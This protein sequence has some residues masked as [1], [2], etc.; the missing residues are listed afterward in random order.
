MTTDVVI[1]A[2]GQGSRMK[3]AVPKVLHK[4][5]G[6]P[7][8][9]HVLDQANQLVNSRLHVVVG[10]GAEQVQ[11]ELSGQS[12]SFAL[13]EQQLGTGHAVAAAMPN[14]DS[15]QSDVVLV[16]YGD[17]PLTSAE[18]MQQLVA[19]AESGQL[20]LLTVKLD[21]P[22]GYGRI[23]RDD[24]DQVVAI[25]EQKDG[26]AEQ[27]KITETNTG[28]LAAPATKMAQ[29]LPM[30]S[31]DN[32]QSEYYL[33]DIIALAAGDGTGVRA[34]HPNNEFEVQGVN[35]RIQQARLERWYQLQQA[36]RL[37][38][39]GVTLA[40][41]ARFDV[42]GEV[43]VGHDVQIDINVIFEGQVV[44]G[45]NVTIE[46]NVVIKDAQIGD[47]AHIKANSH[48]EQAKVGAGAE[49]GPFARLRTGTDL[50]AKSKV[51]N[52]VETKKTKLGAGS[53]VN[54]LS[55]IG[56]SEVGTG[57]N[58]G[59][60]TITCNYDGVNKFRTEIGDGA[61][62][63]SNTALVAPVTVGKEATVAAGSIVTKSVDDDTLAVARAK[64]RNISGWTKPTKA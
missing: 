63:G 18:T 61:F 57:V 19:I 5:G 20:G 50:A 55:Y 23:I 25:V 4:I 47:G 56:D 42:R 1:L 9:Q 64:Q 51:G 26:N 41:P 62:I 14:I 35:D 31:S 36:N 52:F 22:T 12:V 34:I 15:E 58:I 40:D 33:T 3:S 28:I 37:M 49:V 16:L 60:G 30:L 53:K 7:M 2:A 46:S 21:D 6:K 45:N 13:Q 44:L 48:I 54:H 59:A 10:H 43:T 27:L 29:W 38:Q 11:S 17:V 24:Q 8:V 32:A 39:E